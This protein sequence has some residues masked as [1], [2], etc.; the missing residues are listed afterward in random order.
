MLEHFVVGIRGSETRIHLR[1]GEPSWFD[2]PA[3]NFP[4]RAEPEVFR[5]IGIGKGG[6]VLAY[7][8]KVPEPKLKTEIPEWSCSAYWVLSQL[9]L[10]SPNLR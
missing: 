9:A 8:R 2:F 4:K 1:H 3:R 5:P 6:W 10:C 7:I